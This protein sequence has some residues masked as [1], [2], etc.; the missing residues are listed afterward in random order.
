M[1]NT[2]YWSSCQSRTTPFGL[3]LTFDAWRTKM[4]Q[5]VSAHVS[6]PRICINV[7]V[8]S[9][10]PLT[11]LISSSPS[12]HHLQPLPAQSTLARAVRTHS[13]E[14]LEV[15]MLV[16]A[17][18]SEPWHTARAEVQA[19]AGGFEVRRKGGP[20]ILSAAEPFTNA[21]WDAR[22]VYLVSTITQAT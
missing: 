11:H 14:T 18:S 4:R 8:S 20:S 16:T 5:D 17:P 12:L 13:S 2:Q 19:P 21:F 1:N 3:T 15:R 22:T 10:I 9:D 6:N 7:Q